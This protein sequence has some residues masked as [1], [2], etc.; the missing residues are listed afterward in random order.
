MSYSRLP[1]DTCA[2]KHRLT[3]SIGPGEYMLDRNNFCEP[4][5]VPD[6]SINVQRYG[7]SLCGKELIDVD[8]ELLGLNYKASKCPEKAY[9]P[10]D[11]RFCNEVKLRE[12]NDLRAEN[13]R[14]SNPPCTLRCTGVNRF[15]FPCQ[16]PQANVD[17]L[18]EWNI[19]N[20]LVVK[21]NHR[22]CIP[23]PISQT[24][25]LPSHADQEPPKFCGL[26]GEV[27]PLHFRKCG[28]FKK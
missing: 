9:L 10:S 14:L 7:A 15:E 1:Y 11:K 28:E 5:F 13:T 22:P 16:D 3:E 27:H 20:R 25:A 12:C 19:N 18:F 6:P 26:A 23:K 8:S 2:Y 24:M 21:D 17:R 4:C